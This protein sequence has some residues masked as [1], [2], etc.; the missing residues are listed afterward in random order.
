MHLQTTVSGLFAAGDVAE[1]FDVAWGDR[2]LHA[3]WPAAVEQ[4]R[5]A[6][7]NMTGEGIWYPGTIACNAL[8]IEDLYIVSGG[9]SNPSPDEGYQSHAYHDPSK[10]IYKKIVTKDGRMAGMVFVNDI[11]SAGIVLSMIKKKRLLSS[12]K[13]DCLSARFN[14]GQVSFII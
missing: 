4:G 14:A 3:L 13:A 1:T 9:I 5:I 12:V 11:A 2:R 7:C 10:R 6:G 8:R